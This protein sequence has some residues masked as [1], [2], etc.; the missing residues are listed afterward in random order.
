VQ[1]AY[2]GAKIT[3]VK[4]ITYWAGVV[5]LEGICPKKGL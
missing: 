2:T 1:N 5:T 4:V 3:N